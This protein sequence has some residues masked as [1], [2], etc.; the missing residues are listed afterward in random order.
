MSGKYL[1][2]SVMSKD[3]LEFAEREI[4]EKSSWRDRDIQALRDMVQKND[5]KM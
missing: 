4:N 1:Y 2:E 5:G 3:L